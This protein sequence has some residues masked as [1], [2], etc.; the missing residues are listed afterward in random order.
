MKVRKYTGAR[1]DFRLTI[2]KPAASGLTMSVAVFG[3]H[4]LLNVLF[5]SIIDS[6]NM[7]NA[8]A[9]ALAILTGV[10]VY[11]FMLFATRAIT[12]E[13]LKLMPKGDKLIRIFAR[14]KK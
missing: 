1:F 3:V 9:T 13:E 2:I 8:L 6:T 5:G 10:V 7:A 11:V 12:S 4:R 14:F